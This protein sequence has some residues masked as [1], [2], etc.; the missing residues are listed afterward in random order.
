MMTDLLLTYDMGPGVEAF[1]TRRDSVL[2]YPV[3]TGHQVHGNKVGKVDRPGLI[4]EDL[5]GFDALITNL[6]GEAIGVRTAD[7]VPILLYDPV[8][9]AVAA[10]HSGWRGTLQRISQ[11]AM[12]AM[13][14]H[15]GCEPSD[16]RAVMGPAIGKESFQVGAEVV[17]M[18]KEQGFPLDD[19]WSFRE[20]LFKEKVRGGH[21]ID[22]IRAN[23]WLLEE[24]GVLPGN[25]QSTD[26]DT[27]TDGSFF[28]ARREG[29]DC[30]RTISAIRLK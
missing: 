20:G 23:R 3:V 4:R 18:F 25:I 10:V 21:H 7:C 12:F 8:C 6:E 30:G 1:S 16:I 13:K 17:I 19:I 24:Y 2:P 11:K 14:R 29:M 26:I 22:L 15:F 9:R 27:F 5:E 28:S